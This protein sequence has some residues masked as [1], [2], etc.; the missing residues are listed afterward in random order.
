MQLDN[1]KTQPEGIPTIQAV[2]ETEN[3]MEIMEMEKMDVEA[4]LSLNMIV[5][6]MNSVAEKEEAVM[7]VT[8]LM[9][10]KERLFW[11]ISE[12]MA[13]EVNRPQEVCQIQNII[14]GEEEE[15]R[16]ALRL[17]ERPHKIRNNFRD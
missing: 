15:K 3:I 6:N 11:V 17:I 2:E 4:I 16:M 8:S 5:M 1:N 14:Q 10:K 7:L 13:K 9:G 12:L